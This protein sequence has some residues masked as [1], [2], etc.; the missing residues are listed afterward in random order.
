MVWREVL[1]P[2]A[3]CQDG[4]VAGLERGMREKSQRLGARRAEE[5]GGAETIRFFGLTM[6]RVSLDLLELHDRV[7]NGQFQLR[8]FLPLQAVCG[9]SRDYYSQRVSHSTKGHSEFCWQDLGYPRGYI[10][11]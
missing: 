3:R 9:W 8:T 2:F 4:Q 11:K 10:L 7:L 6:A 5:R 1:K